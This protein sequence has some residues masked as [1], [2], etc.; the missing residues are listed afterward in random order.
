MNPT[1]TDRGAAP[2]ALVDL[3]GVRVNPVTESQVVATVVQGWRQG[4]G[5]LIVTPNV[6]IW[7][8]ARQDAE[9]AGIID[10]ADLVVADGQPLVW[11]SQLAGT[12]VPE[13]VTGSGLVESLCAA[14]AV[15]G[16][17]VYIVGGG[18]DDVAAR[19]A[20]ALV[21]RHDGLRVVG[22]VVPPFGFESAPQQLNALVEGVV[23]TKPDVVLVGLGFPKQERLALLLKERLPRAW[24]LGCGGGV[25]MAA[26]DQRRSPVWA[27]RVGVEWLV[28]L[29]QEPRRLGRRYVVDGL[30]AAARLLSASAASRW[31]LRSSRRR[32]S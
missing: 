21:L 3:S 9:L 32:A 30:P 15:E 17:R 2:S 29:A 10:A 4:T 14:A 27:Q 23:A 12:P 11:A 20:A 16:C 26:G 19:A 22:H 5:G 24:F 13:R 1:Q 8:Q 31:R 28:R 25:A 7:R 6:D 18:A